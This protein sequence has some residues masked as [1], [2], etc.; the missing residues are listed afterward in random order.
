MPYANAT[1]VR[2]Y[3]EVEGWGPPLMLAHAFRR[4]LNRWRQIGFAGAL[5]NDYRLIL[6]DAR[7]HGESDKPH[8]P[9][10]Y[11]TKMVED[12]IAVLDDLRVD[13][14]HY[15]GY[16]MGAGVGFK[17][18]VSHPDRFT[19][20]ILGGFSPY[21]APVSGNAPPARIAKQVHTLP[22]D[23]EMFLR[24][25][26]QQL[27]RPPAPDEKE[28]ELAN[29]LEALSAVTVTWGEIATLTDQEL[30]RITVPCLLYAGDLDPAY[31]GAKEASSHIPG[32]RF[33][34]LRGLNHAQ[35]GPDLQ[36]IRHVKEFLAQ[37]G[38]T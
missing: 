28:A 7:G 22:A 17:A 33:L 10:A 12:V 23:P 19:S 6:F 3:Y 4:N 37:V 31:A 14:T 8:D 21:P 34:S 24:S 36:V 38:Q 35:A 2:I 9:A 11:G 26:E 25:V 20:F 15:F 1:G 18:A 16:S 30:S 13:R 32:A 29:D 27:G 5:K